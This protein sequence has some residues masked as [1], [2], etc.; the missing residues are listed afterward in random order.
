MEL[1]GGCGNPAPGRN[2]LALFKSD[3]CLNWEYMTDIINHAEC[4]IEEVVFNIHQFVYLRIHYM[5]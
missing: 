4:D 5:C 2:V 1:I 3:D